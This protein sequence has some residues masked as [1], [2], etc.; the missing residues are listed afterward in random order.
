MLL[1]PGDADA[2]A[3]AMTAM[4]GD[5]DERRRMS[6][7]GRA[8]VAGMTWK[9]TADASVDAYRAALAGP[10]IEGKLDVAAADDAAAA[11]TA[12]DDDGVA[13]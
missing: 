9:A 10:A 4:L 6:D 13:S 2:W 3:R 8:R 7:A 11:Q 12:T 1:P 5:E